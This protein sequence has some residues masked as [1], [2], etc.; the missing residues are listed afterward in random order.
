MAKFI[1]GHSRRALVSQ[2]QAG[3]TSGASADYGQFAARPIF[4]IY[5]LMV[6]G[7]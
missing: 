1:D 6:D 2:S 4:Q 3:I 7:R 5:R